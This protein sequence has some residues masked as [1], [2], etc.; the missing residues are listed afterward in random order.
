MSTPKERLEQEIK[1]VDERLVALDT[2]LSK[3]RPAFISELQWELL[4]EQYKHQWSYSNVLHKR[5]R[6]WEL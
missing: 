2:L 4:H 5:L 1:E 3:D 6:A